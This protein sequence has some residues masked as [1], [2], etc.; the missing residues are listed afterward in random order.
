MVARLPDFEWDEAKRQRTL[1]DRF[2]DFED[3]ALFFDGRPAFHQPTPRH[4]EER[5]KTTAQISGLM[6]TLV[7]V[8]R[9]D[10]I[11]VVSMR[12]SHVSEERAYRAAFGV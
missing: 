9:L 3:A 1:A 12:R 8:R 11:R 4:G 7:W 2:L 10:A 6:V 5:W